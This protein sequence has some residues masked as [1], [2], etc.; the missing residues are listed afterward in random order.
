MSMNRA[1]VVVMVALSVVGSGPTLAQWSDAPR[2]RVLRLADDVG[3]IN[4]WRRIPEV[5]REHCAKLS[6]EFGAATLE[7]F[8]SWNKTHRSLIALIDRLVDASA[9]PLTSPT[10][11]GVE[12][13]RSAIADGTRRLILETYFEGKEADPLGVC[14]KYREVL[15]GLS[16]AGTVARVRGTAYS[17]ESSSCPINRPR[18]NH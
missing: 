2:D 1:V 5:T 9:S 13:T 12:G 4:A 15:D 18:P 10:S 11:D 3:T 6:P 17:V 16:K 14:W 7:S 8:A